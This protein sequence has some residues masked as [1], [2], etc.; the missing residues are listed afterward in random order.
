MSSAETYGYLRERQ[1][2]KDILP[3]TVVRDLAADRVGVLQDVFDYK[4]SPL[5]GSGPRKV[6][7]VR[8]VGGGLEWTT[9]PDQLQP[10]PGHQGT[11][12]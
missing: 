5:A 12:P 6:A 9:S 3:G 1:G 10:E 7:F 11:T 2:T 8:P 4:C